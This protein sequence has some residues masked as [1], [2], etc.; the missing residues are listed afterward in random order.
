[1]N[2]S[3]FHNCDS[4]IFDRFEVRSGFCAPLNPVV[5]F[6]IKECAYDHVT[7]YDGASAEDKT[8]GRFCGNKLP[9][10]VVANTN[11]MYVV[12]KSDASVQRKGFLATHSTGKC[13]HSFLYF[14]IGL[15]S[16]LI[17]ILF[18]ST[19]TDTFGTPWK[20]NIILSPSLY[21]Y[22]IKQLALKIYRYRITSIGF[23]I[24][25]IG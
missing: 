11:Q 13:A 1:M 23:C 4:N 19:H 7:I 25:G 3:F 22:H 21:W 2:L 6:V 8:L 5:R 10:P 17:R 18:N 15:Q 9:H 14:Y 12:F 16:Y 20:L 24:D